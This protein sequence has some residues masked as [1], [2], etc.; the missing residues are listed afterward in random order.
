M[1]RRSK[2]L[3]LEPMHVLDGLDVNAVI[4]R[5]FFEDHRVALETC[6][7]GRPNPGRGADHR[8]RVEATA[9]EAAHLT[10]RVKASSNGRVEE[11]AELLRVVLF[12]GV[13][14]LR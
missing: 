5:G 11:I 8:R 4:H 7:T 6:P 12:A 1:A 13:T 14:D 10:R 2:H 3:D 9:N